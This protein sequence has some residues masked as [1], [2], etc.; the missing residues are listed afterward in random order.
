MRNFIGVDVLANVVSMLRAD[1]DGAIWVSDHDEEARF[2]ETR[3][4][5]H[6][7]RVISAPNAAL[8]VLSIVQD[9]GVA[10]VVAVLSSPMEEVRPNIF[11]PE[12]GDVASILLGSESCS[13][14]VS[15]LT[16]L[17]WA[18]ACERAVGPA[19][20]HAVRLARVFR[21]LRS[22][23]EGSQQALLGTA[24]LLRSVISWESLSIEWSRVAE[25]FRGN[26]AL[27]TLSADALRVRYS[28]ATDFRSD[29]LHCNGFE[30]IEILTAIMRE[31][32]PRGLR[33]ARQ[34]VDFHEMVSALRVALDMQDFEH[35]E[36]F[37]RMRGWERGS[38]YPL[39]RLWRSLDP[40]QVVWDQRY[41]EGDLAALLSYAEARHSPF[42]AWKMDLD[43]FKNVNTELGH[44][45]GDEAIRVYCRT[46][47][48]VLGQV[49]E[50]YRRGGDEVVAFAPDID[51]GI[52]RELAETLRSRIQTRMADWGRAKGL[53]SPPTASIGVVTTRSH[54]S[55]GEVIRELDSSQQ[56]AKEKG[57]NRVVVSEL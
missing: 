9:R 8:R 40:L 57:K 31:F 55:A 11:R 50:V 22:D 4:A 38:G 25:L 53:T 39:L 52:A 7:S 21:D 23:A 13:R 3:C 17:D 51:G 49:A 42:A 5:H 14:V 19:Q 28:G 1:L 56:L 20:H 35:D 15:D 48:D 32:R 47:K 54:I 2:Y 6:S 12:I 41:W 27:G 44:A 26:K 16:G 24:P 10:G 34:T 30:A 45:G 36:V 43:N 33:S 29:L 37:W 46:V 18:K